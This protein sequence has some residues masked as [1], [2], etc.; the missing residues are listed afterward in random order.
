MSEPET[1]DA[2]SPE[3]ESVAIIGGTGEQGLGLASRFAAAG[4]RV[5]IGSRTTERAQSAADDVRKRVP[6]ADVRGRENAEAARAA[7]GGIVILS[8]PFEHTIPT[9]RGIQAS[10]ATGSVLVSMGVP[11]ATAIGD[12]AARTL[13][14][15]QGS[16]AE[17]C[18]E[19]APEGVAVVSA[20]QNVSAHRLLALEDPIDCDVIV[21]GPTAE[22]R[23]VMALCADLPGARAIDGGPLYNARYVENLTALL[24]GL[25][26][27]YKN[28][29]GLGLRITY[30]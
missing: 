4:R 2:Q 24:I 9:L 23:R 12:V 6:R 3:R 5:V 29:A 1:R 16:C 18:R 10:L 20:F 17:L 28:R 25:N 27:R 21:S 11:L 8:V 14:V 19:L 26:I 7:A 15:S 13:G 30:L 22:R